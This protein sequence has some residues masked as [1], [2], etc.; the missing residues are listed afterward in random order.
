MP[1]A[2]IPTIIRKIYAT[3]KSIYA[4]IKSTYIARLTEPRTIPAVDILLLFPSFLATIP[5]I[6]A[7]VPSEIPEQETTP[8]MPHTKDTIA[9][10]LATAVSGA[11][12]VL[13]ITVVGFAAGTV[14]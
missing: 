8:T 2:P 5:K 9:I 14:T 10:A 6:S 13:L 12:G 11:V 4:T 3:K 1:I 7:I